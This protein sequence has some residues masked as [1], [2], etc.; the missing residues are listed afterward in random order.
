MTVAWGAMLFII[1][2]WVYLAA[3]VCYLAYLS[4]P[5]ESVGRAG[6]ALLMVGLALHTASLLMRT[7]AL[8]RPPFLT[9]YDYCVSCL[10]GAIVVY[11]AVETV[12]KNRFVGSFA[13]PL[14]TCLAYLASRLPALETVIMPALRSEW[15]IPHIV[16]AIFAYGAFAVAFVMALVYLLATKTENA[17]ESFWARRLPASPVIDHA[18]YRVVAF[19]F[20]MQT[21]VIVVGALWAQVAWGRLWGW[22]PKET[23]SLIT[24]LIYAAYLHTRTM[25]GWR[26]QRSVLMAL[27]G[28]MATLFTLLGV[29]YLL[30]G[31]HSYL[32]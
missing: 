16:S 8:G 21:L 25:L 6:R 4:K 14:V 27:F 5:R 13:V 31:L 20:L 3:T 32:R 2:F 18:I 28:F 30:P 22:D 11:L 15:R 17:P 26:G 23:W 9:I 7:V 29:S 12:T 24:W 19:G 1:V 10:W